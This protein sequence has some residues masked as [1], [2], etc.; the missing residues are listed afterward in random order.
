MTIHSF[1][2]RFCLLYHFFGGK[3]EDRSTEDIRYGSDV[4]L[5]ITS[6]S[7][8]DSDKFV[9]SGTFKR[10]SANSPFLLL[11]FF[12]PVAVSLSSEI[13]KIRIFDYAKHKICKKEH[14][15]WKYKKNHLVTRCMKLF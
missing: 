2:L 7:D 6:V 5:Y 8:P 13:A 1:L 12:S 15:C 11:K 3:E 4:E 14:I 10:T 9:L